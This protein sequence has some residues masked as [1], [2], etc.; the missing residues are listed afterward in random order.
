MASNE[1]PPAPNRYYGKVGKQI[2]NKNIVN[3]ALALTAIVAVSATQQA[4]ADSITPG[5]ASTDAS[6]SVSPYADVSVTE[7]NTFA[8][9]LAEYRANTTDSQSLMLTA[10][11]NSLGGCR[12]NV[13]ALNGGLRTAGAIQA[14]DILISAGNGSGNSLMPLYTP[15]STQDAVMWSNNEETTAAGT[16]VPVDVKVANLKDYIASGVDYNN[17]IVFT[18]VLN[19]D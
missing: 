13:K 11:T 12:I 15:L 9:T 4:H 6:L 3:I 5:S 8:P 17:T 14:G 16:N 7:L 10:F 2:M 1:S 18:A 19:A